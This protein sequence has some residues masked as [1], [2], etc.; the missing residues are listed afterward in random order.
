[1]FKKFFFIFITSCFY[2]TSLWANYQRESKWAVSPQPLRYASAFFGVEILAYLILKPDYIDQGKKSSDFDYNPQ[3][4]S[5]PQWAYEVGNH[6][7]TL[8]TLGQYLYF[9]FDDDD[10]NFEKAYILTESLLISQGSI[11]TLKYTFNSKR[12][13]QTNHLSFPSGHTGHAFSI[14][15]FMAMDIYHGETF[16][17]NW[18]AAALPLAYA[19]FIGF[20]R[21]DAEKHRAVDVGIGAAIGTLTSYL[22]YKYHFDSNGNYKF[23]NQS[24]SSMIIPNMDPINDSYSLSW[25]YTF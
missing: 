2:T 11:F 12:P 4:I 21:I 19:T 24:T 6:G 10:D 16:H 7:P 1:M 8:L 22:L 25:R 9:Y 20:T 3:T 15:T 5:T 18:L 23:N 13:D 17:K 14:A